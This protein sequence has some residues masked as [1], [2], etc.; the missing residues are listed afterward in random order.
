MW[1]M[2]WNVLKLGCMMYDDNFMLRRVWPSDHFFWSTAI[3]AFFSPFM[4]A[5][6][7][8][9]NAISKNVRIFNIGPLFQKLWPLEHLDYHL[10]H[11]RPRGTIVHCK[12][13]D[14]WNFR[15]FWVFNNNASKFFPK[16][17]FISNI[18]IT[19][20]SGKFSTKKAEYQPFWHRTVQREV[21]PNL[22]L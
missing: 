9:S 10:T 20:Y 14:E 18:D 19:Q 17:C 2:P 3:F 4:I 12:C 8:A 1:V 13:F 11:L 22:A 5:N 16:P 21:F 7:R 15:A 6:W